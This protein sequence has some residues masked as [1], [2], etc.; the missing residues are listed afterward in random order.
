MPDAAAFPNL[1]DRQERLEGAWRN[2]PPNGTM[3]G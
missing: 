1:D 2:R 3:P